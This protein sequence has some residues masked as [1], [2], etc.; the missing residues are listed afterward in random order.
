MA[1]LSQIAECPTCAAIEAVLRAGRVP[2]PVARRIGRSAGK[3]LSETKLQRAIVSKTPRARSTAEKGLDKIRS[4]SMKKANAKGRKKNG[5]LRSGFT[6]AMIMKEA[7]RL[8]KIERR[9]RK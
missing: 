6:Q 2:A 4:D 9:K 5:D 8:M 3:K 1:K 7:H